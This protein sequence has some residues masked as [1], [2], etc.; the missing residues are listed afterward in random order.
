M[1]SI[2]SNFIILWYESLSIC[3]AINKKFK[4]IGQVKDFL[5]DFEDVRPDRKMS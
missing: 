1:E 5:R 2:H 4:D 3:R